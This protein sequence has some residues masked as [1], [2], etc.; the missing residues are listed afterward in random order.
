MHTIPEFITEISIFAVPTLFAIILH[1]VMHGVTA[2]ALGDDTAMR[3]GRLTLNPIAHIDL[4]GTIILP[5]ILI[6][7]SAPVFGYAKPVPVNFGRLRNPR[8]GMM[9]VAAAGPVTNLALAS[10][11]ILL[12]L[13]IAP[14]ENSGIAPRVFRPLWM[15]LQASLGVNVALAIFNLIPILPLDGGRVLVSILPLRFA[16]ALARFEFAGL[17]IIFVLLYS[18]TFNMI[19]SGVIDTVGHVLIAGISDFYYRIAGVFS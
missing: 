3:A 9:M 4:F 12:M 16:R 15:M 10:L 5:A 13:I 14:Y 6:F 11:S 1:E 8:S 18:N 19:L 7:F 2:R 17:L